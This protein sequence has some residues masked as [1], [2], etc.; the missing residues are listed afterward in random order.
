MGVRQKD[1]EEE[2][3]SLGQVKAPPQKRRATIRVEAAETEDYVSALPLAS[4]MEPGME[5]G[6]DDMCDN[7]CREKD[8]KFFQIAAIVTEGGG[9][10]HTLN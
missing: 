4:R 8:F 6:I 3:R 10:A 2:Q 5:A 1:T 7:K 9:A